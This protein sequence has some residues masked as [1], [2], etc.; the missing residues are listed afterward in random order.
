MHAYIFCP[1]PSEHLGFLK[2]VVAASKALKVVFVSPRDQC[3]LQSFFPRVIVIA[4]DFI[5]FSVA[6]SVFSRAVAG[7]GYAQLVDSAWHLASGICLYSHLSSRT[8]LNAAQRTTPSLPFVDTAS[9]TGLYVPVSSLLWTS[10]PFRSLS[11]NLLCLFWS[12]SLLKDLCSSAV[13]LVF[14]WTCNSISCHTPLV[15]IP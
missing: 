7:Y 15:S 4:P 13:C 12:S 1:L 10:G 14:T 2:A 11:L 5:H 3:E 9:S 6:M 8:E